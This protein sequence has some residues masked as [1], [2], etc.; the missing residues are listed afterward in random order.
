[1]SASAVTMIVRAELSVW[2]PEAAHDLNERCV[3]V[4]VCAGV[5]SPLASTQGIA[6]KRCPVTLCTNFP[7]A[8]SV[9]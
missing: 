6:S 4:Q 9:T 1:M 8:L 2:Q 7:V 5:G 3:I